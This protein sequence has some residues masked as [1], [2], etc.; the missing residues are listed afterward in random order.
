M[1]ATMDNASLPDL[2]KL[3]ADDA[4]ELVRAEVGLAKDEATKGL[5]IGLIAIAGATAATVIAVLAIGTLIAAIVLGAGGTAV[6][7]L[8]AAAGWGAAL[9][10]AAVLVSLRILA[11]HK[12]PKAVVPEAE[13]VS[14]Q[15]S[16]VLR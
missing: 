5:R 1:G 9:V 11:K 12:Q 2:V 6:A 8:A 3:L 7:A 4:R 14:G 15:Q 13:V 16:E 10:I